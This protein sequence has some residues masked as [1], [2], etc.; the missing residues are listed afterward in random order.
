MKSAFKQ[1]FSYTY[2]KNNLISCKVKIIYVDRSLKWTK[3]HNNQTVSSMFHFN[4]KKS[5][6]LGSVTDK[7]AGRHKRNK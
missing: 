2:N 5:N 6:I 7:Q 1:F 4:I 3:L